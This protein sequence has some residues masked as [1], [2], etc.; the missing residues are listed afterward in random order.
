MRNKIQLEGVTLVTV[1]A[2]AVQPR[3]SPVLAGVVAAHPVAG[4]TGC[5]RTWAAAAQ[6]VAT[7]SRN[8]V[9]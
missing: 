1:L 4:R 2:S 8:G 6:A 9:S 3:S 7:G 5:R